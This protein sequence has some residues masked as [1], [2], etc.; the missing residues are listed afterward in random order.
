MPASPT[1]METSESEPV[2]LCQAFSDV[3]LNTAIRDVD[4]DDY[5]NPMLCSEYVKDIYKYMRQLEEE[6]SVRP[7]YLKGQEVTGTMRAILIDWLVQVSMKFRLLQETMYM[8]VGLIDRFLQEHPVS[9]KHL[10]LVGVTA[11][12]L[13]SKYEEIYPP[14]IGDFAHVTDSAY[15]T[16][17]IRE[18][19]MTFLRVLRFQLGRPLPLQFLRRASKICEVTAEQHTLAKYL[20]E[21][22][23]VD[24]D[25][26]HF[27]PSMVASAALAL[28]LKITDAGE[29]DATLT[30]YMGYTA[31][32]LTPVMAH[33]AKN[34]VKVNKGL[35]K[36]MAVKA[37]YSSSR[38]MRIATISQLTSAVVFDMAKQISQW[39]STNQSASRERAFKSE[40][41]PS[42]AAASSFPQ[43]SLSFSQQHLDMASGVTRNRLVSTRTAFAGK[44]CSATARPRSALGEI[45]NVALNKGLQ[46]KNAKN[47]VVKKPKATV[48]APKAEKVEQPVTVPAVPDVPDVQE[49]ASPTPME[50]SGCEPADLCQAFS[51]VMLD[52]AIRDVDADDYDNPMLCSEYVKEIYK[53]MRQLEEEQSVRPDYLKGQEVTGNMRAILIDWLVQ[54]GMKFRLLQETMYMTVGLIDRFLQEHPVSKKQLQLVGVTAMFLASKYEEIYPP[55]ISDF[56]YVTDQA[57]TTAQI[58][59]AERSLLR[60]LKFQLGRPLPLQFLR[61]ASKIYEVTAEQHTL[62]KY[63]LELTMVD[64]DMVHFPPSMVASAALALTL[65]ITDAG[66]WDATLTHYMGYTAESLTPIMAHIAKNVVKVNKGLTKHMAVK[67]KYS[68]SKQMRIATISQLTSAVVSDM[69]KQISQ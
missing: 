48:A 38:Q 19:E 46:A 60:V 34:V 30:H 52:T 55:E 47:E 59:E 3:L 36:H 49:H 28:T 7:D 43:V 15:T 26:V 22:T 68:S 1:P 29:W 13:A 44:A 2:E 9:K 39:S 66:E 24:Y 21:L 41:C 6:Q 40:H 11:M 62:A 27:P 65:K 10:Q 35:T 63:L 42:C 32:S 67:A 16:A 20:L 56:A 18:T 50:T 5:D 53:Y 64:Y 17:Q 37:K 23:M 58:R 14:E 33:I 8:T 25:M 31:E 57:Y 61:R 45:G 51:D 54:V 12:F 4:A 69:A